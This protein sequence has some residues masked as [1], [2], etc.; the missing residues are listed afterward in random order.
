MGKKL[1]RIFGCRDSLWTWN[2]AKV[3]PLWTNDGVDGG[4]VLCGGHAE[5]V[6]RSQFQSRISLEEGRAAGGQ[7]SCPRAHGEQHMGRP[8]LW[9]S[10]SVQVHIP[11][12]FSSAFLKVITTLVP[13]SSLKKEKEKTSPWYITHLGRE[14][15]GLF[16]GLTHF[17]SGRCLKN[18]TWLFVSSSSELPGRCHSWTLGSVCV[19]EI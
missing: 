8:W 9:T 15:S 5:T 2:Q 14:P 7:G 13:T 4:L 1:I 12:V 6:S 3:S 18:Q 19:S 16:L 17:P 10:L 11:T